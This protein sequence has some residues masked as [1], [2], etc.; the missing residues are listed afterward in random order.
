MSSV[1]AIM[2]F[3]FDFPLPSVTIYSIGDS[4]MA[5][6]PISSDYPGRGWMQSLSKYATD[7]VKINNLAVS[8][9]SSKSFR[10]KG[11]WKKVSLKLKPN[12]YVFIQFGHN[13]EKKD[14]ARATEAT[15]T[16]KSNLQ[17]YIQEVRNN[18]AIP[19]L[20][21]SIVRRKF[22]EQGRLIDT[23]GDYVEV[24]R[25]LAKSENVFLI[26]LNKSSEELV[27][28][29]G[30]DPSK[31]I[32]LHLKPGLYKKYPKGLEDNTH[33]S[34]FG[35]EQIAKLVIKELDSKNHPLMH[36]FKLK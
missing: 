17:Y 30:V 23:H 6:Y 3:A 15:T 5:E 22:N 25:R 18:G 26:D 7:E 10:E 27:E 8:G 20:L 28:K 21:T 31:D 36:F 11:Y 9:T 14:V 32:F 24:V 29:L 19:V 4:T 33:L 16:F 35:S 12:D 1:L 2:L 34:E 13:D